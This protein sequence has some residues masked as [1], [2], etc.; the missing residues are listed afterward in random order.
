MFLFVTFIAFSKGD[1]QMIGQLY[2][3]IDAANSGTAVYVCYKSAVDATVIYGEGDYSLTQAGNTRT[4]HLTGLTPGKRYQYRV[5]SNGDTSIPGSFRTSPPA[6]DAFSIAYFGDPQSCNWHTTSPY[7]KEIY[8]L[9]HPDLLIITGDL[10][11]NE[12]ITDS[13]PLISRPAICYDSLFVL[14]PELFANTILIPARGNHDAIPHYRYTFTMLPDQ[15]MNYQFTYGSV[16]FTVTEYV[17]RPSADFLTKIS[18]SGAAFK[19][20]IMHDASYEGYSVTG[21]A[22]YVGAPF[23]KAGGDIFY[24][25]HHHSYWRTLWIQS[26]PYTNPMGSIIDMSPFQKPG[27]T[28]Y[29]GTSSPGVCCNDVKTADYIVNFNTTIPGYDIVTVDS[30]GK[31]IYSSRQYRYST[32]QSILQDSFIVYDSIRLLTIVPKVTRVEINSSAT[33]FEQYFPANLPTVTAYFQDGH[34]ED[35]SQ[36]VYWTSLDKSR[37][38]VK[39][40]QVIGLLSGTVSIRAE[41][42][43]VS[44]TMALSFVPTTLPLDSIVLVPDSF[45]IFP[46]DSY[47]VSARGYYHNG[48]TK[49]SHWLSTSENGISWSSSMPSIAAVSSG[50]VKGV[51][52][53]GP[54]A[55]S[56]SAGS[57][58]GRSYWTIMPKPA[59]IKRINF[60]VSSVPFKF[61]WLADNATAYSA[62]KGYGW[63]TGAG[64][65]TRD[66][67]YGTNFLL[68]S[69]VIGN[70]QYKIDAS[71]GEY[72][73]RTGMGDNTY[74]VNS[75]NTTTFG[76]DTVCRKPAGVGN[77]VT[78]DTI[79]VTGGAGIVLA[80]N[81][82]INYIVVI[83]KQGIDMNDVAD[84]DGVIK[85]GSSRP[86]VVSQEPFAGCFAIAPNPF[87]PATTITVRTKT[88]ARLSIY[89]LS[90]QLLRSWAVPGGNQT[91]R[92]PW[93]GRDSRGRNAA[94]GV[95]AYILTEGG[96]TLAKRVVLAR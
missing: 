2:N 48:S 38:S 34:I 80:V 31:G 8:R 50:W 26:P 5:I 91:H 73:I 86:E 15:G 85:T 95:Y 13:V 20:G 41:Y 83:S 28:L 49:F 22:G 68:K 19:I 74:G 62:Q 29:I 88:S 24:N 87:N 57:I 58:I 90:G 63:V 55:V 47:L 37:A 4:T 18:Q 44:D 72:I 1:S 52:P 35:V 93:D 76:T 36:N 11:A 30:I 79:M 51:S 33:P 84:D 16:F 14:A 60:Q 42:W 3:I 12:S 71:D 81:G 6:G 32:N 27:H 59:F 17:G 67:R 25:G 65:A 43:L 10:V 94:A 70:G 46:A 45:R 66:D 53:G 77:Q 9:S 21:A 75:V 39:G 89:S 82:P 7:M 23:E 40:N 54:A 78:T 92:V 96:K 64:A 56:A 61:G 69:F